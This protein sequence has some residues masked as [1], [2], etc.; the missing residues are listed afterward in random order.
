MRQILILFFFS[1]F[2]F[3]QNTTEYIVQVKETLFSIATKN[4]ITVEDIKKA[5]KQLETTGLQ[6]GQKLII[7][8]A[9]VISSGKET[10]DVKPQETLFSIARLYN[11]S[12]KDLEGLNTDLLKEGLRT[13]QKIYIPN[14]KK[15][16]SGEARIINSETIF[17]TVLAGETKFSIAKKYN[18]AINQLENQ[19][20]E[21][22]NGLKEGNKLAINV[23]AINPKN[24]T[25]E[26]MIALA[27]KQLAIEK[28]K[29]QI[30]EIEELQDKLIVQKQINQKVLKINGLSVNLDKIDASK[31]GSSQKLKLILEANKN[32]QDILVTKLDSLV[33]DMNE[34]L[35]RIKIKDFTN[36]EESRRFEKE[37]YKNLLETNEL[38]RDLKRDLYDNRK[39]YS[40]LMNK[41]QRINVAQ[42]QEIKRKLR[43]SKNPEDKKELASMDAIDQ[44]QKDL[45]ASE[46]KNNLLL[47]KADSLSLE[48]DVIIR[49]QLS[50]ATYY[51]V[52][53]RDYDDKLALQKLK[54]YQLKL[55]EDDKVPTKMLGYSSDELKRRFKT[56]EI[57]LKKSYDIAVYD[58]LPTEKYGFY[59]VVDTFKSAADRDN[60]AR[61][62]SD[63]GEL[64]T[65]FFF[66]DNNFK[67][68]VFTKFSSTIQELYYSMV[69]LEN[70]PDF[71]KMFIVEIRKP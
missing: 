59:L 23:K 49:A 31:S 29:S 30:L 12:V 24:D 57:S 41:V 45:V 35:A 33:S 40:E 15:T 53:A 60:L 11:V 66:N 8:K 28:N 51:S 17:H 13:G 47:T 39:V 6:I 64:N 43:E 37:S 26:L 5:N 36:I 56:G 54:R 32:I 62:M 16:L 50:K 65:S 61:A 67:Y 48:K 22:V 1:N 70:N 21:I 4:G 55:I 7:P 46:K 44:L 42:N 27:E 69:Y 3:A 10:H 2:I 14:K 68:Y 71:A 9:I 63:A 25:E 58:N 38:I 34:D 19:N 20:P 18:I 52:A